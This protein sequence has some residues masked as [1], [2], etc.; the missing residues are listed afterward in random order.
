[1]DIRALSRQGYTTDLIALARIVCGG[2]V[3]QREPAP[4]E[5]DQHHAEQH[6]REQWPIPAGRKAPQQLSG[7]RPRRCRRERFG[8]RAPRKALE[9]GAYERRDPLLSCRGHLAMSDRSPA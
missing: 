3:A 8:N 4:A 9:L 2:R 1:M 5:G 7:W 6:D